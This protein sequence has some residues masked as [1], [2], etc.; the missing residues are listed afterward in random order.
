M[1]TKTSD[2]RRRVLQDTDL[3]PSL[4]EVIVRAIALLNEGDTKVEELQKMLSLDHVLV[5]RILAM[6]NSPF[7]RQ[8]RE[9]R[10]VRDAIMV[11]GYQNLRS[12]LLV[13]SASRLMTRDFAIY[14]HDEKGL[15]YHAVC[16]AA[17]AKCLAVHLSEDPMMQEELF[18]AALLHDIGKMVLVRHLAQLPEDQLSGF[19]STVAMEREL[20]GIT[21]AEAGTLVAAKWNLG[22]LVSIVID[23]HHGSDCEPEYERYVSVVRLADGVAHDEGIGYSAALT[24]QGSIDPADL[25]V[26]DFTPDEWEPVREQLL[27]AMQQALTHL[28]GVAG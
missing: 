1:S 24:P 21:H 15:W 23:R 11:L 14:G 13:T 5:A 20:L 16:V 4:P 6:V 19:E 17:G 26:L 22:P 10:S 8:R 3:I 2:I 12:L 27:E 7:F 9:I 25:Q 28:S 18:I